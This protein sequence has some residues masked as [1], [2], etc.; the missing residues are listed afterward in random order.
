MEQLQSVYTNKSIGPPD[1]YLGKDVK[2]DKK[3]RW[4]VG[5]K[6]YITKA[7]KRNHSEIVESA[8]LNSLD[9]QK[10]QILI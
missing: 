5:C 10:Y 7:L 2:K 1:Y 8:P 6:K 3:E 9:L 4:C